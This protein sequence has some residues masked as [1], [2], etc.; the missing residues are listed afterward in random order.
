[1]RFEVDGMR[2]MDL[3]L[4]YVPYLEQLIAGRPV[5]THLEDVAVRRA[6]VAE[7]R[8]SLVVSPPEDVLIETMEIRDGGHTIPIRVYR[9]RSQAQDQM[10]PAIVYFHGGGWMYGSAEQSDPMSVAYC[11]SVGAVV[12]S[13]D[14]R[15]SPEH[16]FPA[17]FD[18]CYRTLCWV[19]AEAPSLRVDPSRLAVTGESSGGNLAAA[20]AIEARDRG[21][22]SLSLQ[23]LNYPALDVAFDTASYRENAEAPVLSAVEMRYFWD[24]YLPDG[25]DTS[26]PRALPLRASSLGGLAPAHIVVA[27]YDPLRDDG[28]AYAAR[29]EAD[30]TPVSLTHARRLPHGFMRALAMSSDVRDIVDNI[31]DAFQR[32]FRPD[33]Q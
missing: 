31:A 30:G 8:R 4:T 2:P 24:A 6:R 19:A 21:G 27:E 29:L 18:D 3:D 5:P 22:P 1:M 25:L 17:G 13:P 26:D 33:G 32:A 20:C 28:I 15:L 9:P 12:V 23:V 16:P 10:L 11:R 14:Y 7:A